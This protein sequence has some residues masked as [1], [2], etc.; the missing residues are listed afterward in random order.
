MKQLDDGTI[1]P[2]RVWYYL[3]DFN[4][5][6][7]WRLMHEVSGGNRRLGSLT[8][9]KFWELFNLATQTDIQVNHA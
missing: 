9:D 7:S 6:D 2:S 1:V 4:E 8:K 3:L 5:Q